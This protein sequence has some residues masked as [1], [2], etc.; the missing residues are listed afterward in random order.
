MAAAG[1]LLLAAATAQAFA[2][3]EGRSDAD[4]GRGSG[5]R[6]LRLAAIPWNAAATLGVTALAALLVWC[7][8]STH[9]PEG[10]VGPLGGT[11]ITLEAVELP[12]VAGGQARIGG[13]PETDDLVVGAARSQTATNPA[14]LAAGAVRL[15]RDGWLEVAVT[16]SAAAIA[17][18]GGQVVGARPLAAGWRVCALPCGSAS[19]VV[20]LAAGALYDGER[21]ALLAPDGRI[22]PIGGDQMVIGRPTSCDPPWS[23][24]GVSLMIRDAKAP[25]T[26]AAE[27]RGERLCVY[28]ATSRGAQF[29]RLVAPPR[30]G[31]GAAVLCRLRLLACQQTQLQDGRL[32]ALP[33]DQD[34]LAARV[35]CSVVGDCIRAPAPWRLARLER[36][37]V[38]D[39]GRSVRLAFPEPAERLFTPASGET[40]TPS[41][42]IAAAAG[43]DEPVAP[44]ERPAVFERLGHRFDVVDQ[45]LV[46]PPSEQNERPV[47]HAPA[48]ETGGAGPTVV[49][50][51][52]AKAIFDIRTLD[53]DHGLYGRLRSLAALALA[54]SLTATW[55][56]RRA[57]PLAAILLG[58]LD[59][60]LALRLVCAVEGAFMDAAPSVQV[61]PLDALPEL[62]AGPLA[63][64]IAW[65]RAPR[66][67]A[68]VVILAAC[69]LLLALISGANATF[70]VGA[71]A[72]VLIAALSR[73]AQSGTP[74]R[75]LADLARWADRRPLSWL[76]IWSAAMLLG[77][78]GFGYGLDWKEAAHLGP[79]RIAMSLLFVPAIMAAFAPLT[80]DLA[81]GSVTD[82]APRLCV[83]AMAIVGLALGVFAPSIIVKD[84][85]FAI[86]AWPVVTGLLVAWLARRATIAAAGDL[87]L[88][89]LV[90]GAALTFIYALALKM[91]AA[92]LAAAAGVAAVLAGG[93]LAGRP[94][95]LWPAPAILVVLVS[96]LIAAVG[97][98]GPLQTTTFGLREAV[99]TDVNRDRLLA[100][101]APGEIESVGTAAA[102]AYANT[103]A[104][105]RAYSQ[106]LFGRG[107][108]SAP[109]PTAL[110]PYQ[111][112]DNAAAIHIMSPFGR[113]GAVAILMAAVAVAVAATGRAIRAPATLRPW[114]GVLA[115]LTPWLI[116][117]YMIL[118]NNGAA[119]FTG[120]NVYLLS[121]LSISDFIEG[122][123]LLGLV[124]VT[125]G[126]PRAPTT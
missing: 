119:L 33:I 8:L 125:L 95:S 30:A 107:Y 3:D 37:T 91:D 24:A 20:R 51:A 68:G 84:F 34:A 88:A 9:R 59:L 29:A 36:L 56:L 46:D 61:F 21:F 85:G 113:L 100:A 70:Y 5:R 10:S 76:A 110:K 94:G 22:A 57:D 102:E 115:A 80:A 11:R 78:L 18:I 114:L 19:P 126:A 73:L 15:S 49:I 25:A 98:F 39:Q 12:L 99:A 71:V 75:R 17:V 60:F 87:L 16:P 4:A 69:A 97:A 58:A 90:A 31:L 40:I 27:G 82:R 108:L 41:I 111:L 50:G 109:E 63:L 124:A 93:V 7:C 83:C 121:P 65:P 14:P 53:F 64:L 1:G 23:T 112:T 89:A 79:V 47:V 106:P 28:G 38:T 92:V 55:S 6:G 26:R 43:V 77:R 66:R 74:G 116:D 96:L 103:L 81:R 72:V 67:L 104:T 42:R 122:L 35:V 52:G 32:A 45:V 120:R 118:A 13:D 54:T 86:F 44:A 2:T 48:G 117:A 105:M 123:I 62:A 101:F